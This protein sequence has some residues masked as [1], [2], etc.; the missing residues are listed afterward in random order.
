MPITFISLEDLYSSIKALA[1]A[2]LKIEYIGLFEVNEAFAIQV[3]SFLDHFGI[4]DDDARVNL[5]GGAIAVGHPLASSGVRLM[6]NLAR[7]FEEHPEVKYGI[8]TMC[9][10][11]GM[12]GTVIWENP[13][14]NRSSGKAG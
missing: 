9:I 14:F 13:H 5:Y 4:A 7:G 6:I 8:T 3:L 11:L 10:G 1:K 12:G 2:G